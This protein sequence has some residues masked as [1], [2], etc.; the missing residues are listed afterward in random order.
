MLLIQRSNH[1][2]K[3]WVVHRHLKIETTKWNWSTLQRWREKSIHPTLSNSF[4]FVIMKKKVLN[5]SIASF[6]DTAADSLEIRKSRNT[7]NNTQ[8]Y[9]LTIFDRN[10]FCCN[11]LTVKTCKSMNVKFENIISFKILQ[12]FIFYFNILLPFF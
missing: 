6:I 7:Q 10:I 12:F 5:S 4:T 1:T 2:W 8:Y 11:F 3:E 9:A